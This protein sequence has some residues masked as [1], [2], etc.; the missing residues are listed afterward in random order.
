LLADVAAPGA[1]QHFRDLL[2]G[3]WI[4]VP[5]TMQI[6]GFERLAMT[7]TT[8]S[9]ERPRLPAT[10]FY[11][12]QQRSDGKQAYRFRRKDLEP[13]AFA[14]IWEFAPIK[15]RRDLICGDDCR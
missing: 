12:W 10:G 14:G 11:E 6:V 3:F 9:P 8:G 1:R 5:V 4:F 7:E 2:F 15:W 13:F